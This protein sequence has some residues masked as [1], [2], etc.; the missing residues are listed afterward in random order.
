MKTIGKYVIRGLLGRGGMGRIYKVRHPVIGKTAALKILHPSPILLQMVGERKLRQLFVQEAVTLAGLRHPNIVE[1]LEFDED[2]GK[3]FYLMEY[4]VNSLGVMIGEGIHPDEPS[5]KVGIEKAVHYLGQT[6]EGLACLHHAGIVHRDIKPHNLLVTDQDTVK[7]CDFGLS[8][9]RGETIGA[10]SNLKIGSPWYSPPEQEKTP[11]DVGPAA[12][13]YAAGI[14]F[15]RMLTGMLPEDELPPVS[16]FQPDLDRRWDDFV[17]RATALHPHQ[18]FSSAADMNLALNSLFSEWMEK[19]EQLCAI[20]GTGAEAGP[21]QT[22]GEIRLRSFCLKVAPQ[23]A[24]RAFSTDPLRR[25]ARYIRN[26]F[27]S[28]ADGTVSDAATGLMWQ[29]AGSAYPMPWKDAHETVRRLN[30]S[31]DRGWHD[32]RLPT[33]E[34]LMSLLTRFPSGRQY[35]IAPVFDPTQKWLWYVS[36]DMGYIAWQDLDAYFY[37][38]AVRNL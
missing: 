10:P 8:K 31:G 2:G 15:Y 3:P 27:Q 5:R 1:I 13:L 19:K 11:D 32:W 4:Y 38:R 9:L 28:S 7:I 17:R 22:P 35:C 37:V 25:P 21:R 34:E 29:Q 30:L 6:L 14:T 12:D 36:I 18:R 20:P 26:R 24:A 23:E 33:V 16:R